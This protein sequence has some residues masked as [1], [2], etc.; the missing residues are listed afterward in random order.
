M[1]YKESWRHVRTRE[2]TRAS[3]REVGIPRHTAS[4]ATRARQASAL[5]VRGCSSCSPDQRLSTV[6]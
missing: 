6:P 1:C 5:A 3:L 4:M 2:E